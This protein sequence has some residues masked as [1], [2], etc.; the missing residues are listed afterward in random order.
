[1]WK[2]KIISS[3]FVEYH[4]SA[5]SLFLVYIQIFYIYIKRMKGYAILVFYI[6]IGSVYN[7]TI[8][9]KNKI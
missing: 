1:M 6:I 4:D 8:A 7:K 5:K 9:K 2:D 3:D